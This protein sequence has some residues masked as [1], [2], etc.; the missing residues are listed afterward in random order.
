L[1]KITKVTKTCGCTPFTLAKKEYAPGETGT[2][3]VRY[4]ASSRPS[5][6]SK[7]LYVYSNDKK[8]P[9]VKLAIKAMIVNKVEHKPKRLDVMLNKENAGCPE[10]TL[11]SLD[12]KAFAIKGF[13]LNTRFKAGENCI[14]ADYN[15]SVKSQKF[16]LHPKVDIEKLRKAQNGHIEIILTHPECKKSTI[17]NKVLPRFKVNPR[18]LI[19]YKAKP[20]EAVTKEV[21]VVNNYD[22]EF[23]VE[24]TSS[25]KGIIKVLSQEKTGNRC[26]FELEIMPPAAGKKKRIFSDTF[27]VNVD[28]ERLKITLRG[29]YL[30]EGEK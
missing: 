12:K 2:L 8:N 30:R 28:G 29:F 18:S 11:R 7:T 1:L 15:S 26:K 22:E 6:I 4:K 9:K 14:T 24:S 19:V 16:V 5:S 13:K 10:I 3:K 17:P 27:F 20:Q 21:W 23:E 25:K